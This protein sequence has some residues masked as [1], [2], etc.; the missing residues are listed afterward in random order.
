MMPKEVFMETT[1][2]LTLLQFQPS[3]KTTREVKLEK[4]VEGLV[5]AMRELLE[6]EK[7][8]CRTGLSPL[9]ITS[10]Y[11]VLTSAMRLAREDEGRR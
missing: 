7:M 6:V 10:F 1:K 4:S 3:E 5:F 11:D 2:K 9:V 8:T